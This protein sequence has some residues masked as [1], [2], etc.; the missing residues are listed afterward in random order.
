MVEQKQMQVPVVAPTQQPKPQTTPPANGLLSTPMATP[1]T[2]ASAPAT[3][4]PAK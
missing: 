3:T 1:A 2:N 4:T